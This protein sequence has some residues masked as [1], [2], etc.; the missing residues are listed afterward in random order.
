MNTSLCL[1]FVNLVRAC[2]RARC[3]VSLAGLLALALPAQAQ[4]SFLDFSTGL[5][6]WTTQGGT[7][8]HSSTYSFN[9]GGQPYSLT[10]ATGESMIRITPSGSAV[11]GALFADNSLGLTSGTIGSLLNLG[12]SVTNFGI[13]S[14]SFSLSA[15]TYSFAWAYAA[16]DYQPFNDGVLFSVVGEGTQ[17]VTSLARNGS[18]ASDLSG[19]DPGTLILGSYGSTAWITNTFTVSTNGTYQV[20]FASYNWNDTDLDPVFFVAGTAG[21]FTGTPVGTSGGGGTTPNIDTAAASYNASDLGTSVNPAFEGGTLLANTASVSSDLTID[22]AGGTIQAQNGVGATFSGTISN[23]SGA[24]TGTLTI[25]NSGSGGSVTFTGANTYTGTT[26]VATGATLA[27]SGGGSL[28]STTVNVASGATLDNQNGGLAAGATLTNAGTVNLG[29]DETVAALVNSGTLNGTGRTLTA[30]SYA[31]NNGSIINANLGAGTVTSNGSVALN[32]TS[33]AATVN[34]ASGTLTLGAAERLADTA[35]VSLTG[36]LALGGDETIGSLSG[37]G[38]IALGAHTLTVSSGTYAGV[39]SGTGGLTK[40][41]AGDLTLSGANTFTGATQIGAGTLNLTGS[42][43]ST[44]VNVASGATLD[45]A[46]GG[47]AAGATL[48]NAGSVNLG[49]DDTVAAFVNSGT[50]NGTGHTLTAATYALKNGSIV[51]ANLGTGAVTSN[52][53]VALNGTSAASTVNVASGTLTL[54]AAERLADTAA[55][56]LTGNLALGG[57]ETI[58]SLSGAGG[59]ALGAHTLTVSSGT[60]A[61]VASGTGGLTKT[62]AGDLT[63]SG[64]NTFTGAT[65]IGAGTLNLTGSL[66]STSVNV[67]SG[68]TLDNANGGLAA[69]ATLTNAG[70]VNLGADDTVAAFVNSGTLNGTGRTLSAET[71]AL[72]NGSIVNANLGTG[73]VTSNGSV[74]LNGTSAAATVNVASGTLTLGAAER[75]AD[76]AAVSLS[77]NL[78]LGG[79]E[80]IGS[81]TG[82]GDVALGAHMLT[83][84]S[85]NYAGVASGTGGLTKTGMGDLTLS[86]ANTFTGATQIGAGTLNLTGSLASTS[87]NVASGAVLDNANGGLAAGA[88]LTNAGS[89]NLGAADTVAAF[90]NSGTLNGTGHTLTAATYALNNGSIV[91]AN[92]GTGTVTSNGSV[93]LNGTSAAATVNVASGTLSLGAAERL[94]DTAAV[95]LTGNLALGG[96]ETIGSL[97]G[98]GD[99]ALGA[100]TLTL[101][102]GDYAGIASGTGGLT[103]TGMGDLTLSGANTFTGATQIGAGTL[104]LTGS[105]G[106]ASVNVASGATLENVNGGLAVGATLT[107]AGTVNLGADETVAALVNSGTING[108]GRTLTAATYALNNGSIVNANLG[109]GTVTSNGSVALNGTSA[110]AT[111]NVGSGTLSL[112]A[113]ERLADI[114][115]VSLTGNLALGGNETIGSL[116]GSGDVALGAHTLTVS[117]GNYAGVASGTGGLTKTG[118]GDLTLSGAN[119][120]SGATQ[121][122]AGTLNLTGS[123]ASVSVNVA[124]GAILEN[125]NGGLAANATL[126]NA[127]TVNLG[128]DDVVIAFVSTGTLNGTGRTLSAETYSLDDASVINAN[129]G[130]GTVT[131]NGAVLLNGTSAAATVAVQSGTLTLGAAERLADASVVSVAADAALELTGNETVERLISA[132]RLFGQAGDTLHA[133]LYDL[134]DGAVIDANLGHGTLV[135]NGSVLLNG[136]SAAEEVFVQTGALTLGGPDRLADYSWVDI[137]KDAKLVLANGND[138]VRLLTGEGNVELRN[139][140]VLI[141]HSGVYSGTAYSTGAL[142]KDEA[143]LLTLAGENTYERGTVVRRGE[144]DVAGG[145]RL[146]SEVVV[147]SNGLLRING[148]VQGGVTVESG[149]VL[150]GSGRIEQR[151]VNTGLTSPGNSPGVLRVDGDYIEHSRLLIEIDGRAGAGATGGHDQLSVAGKVVINP[152]STLELNRSVANGFEPGFGDRFLVVNAAGGIEGRYSFLDRRAFGTQLLFDHGTGYVYGT[153]LTA[154]DDFGAAGEGGS[155]VLGGIFAGAV[156]ADDA[157]QLSFFDSRSASGALVSVL[158]SAPSLGEA[159]D[160]LTPVSYVS[161]TDYALHATRNHA[162]N[163]HAGS[164]LA[165]QP[166]WRLTGGYSYLKTGVEKRDGLEYDFVSRGGTVAVE[167]DVT[168]RAALGAFVTFDEG[169][170]D[171]TRLRHEATGLAVGVKGS[172]RSRRPEAWKVEAGASWAGYD[173]EGSR[174]AYLGTHRAKTEATARDAW[175][176]GRVELLRGRHAALAGR[177]LLAYTASEVD[178]FSEEPGLDAFAL[179]RAKDDQLLGEL[180]VEATASPIDRLRVTASAAFVHNFHGT[181]RKV[182]GTLVNGGPAIRV[183]GRGFD[184]DAV[185]LGAGV[186]YELRKGVTVAAGGDALLS[187]GATAARSL[188]VRVNWSF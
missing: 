147:E 48:T 45:N 187:S 11:V 58:G 63:L 52:G 130:T 126:T 110:A 115:A 177:A 83:V 188:N 182:T 28:A 25:A 39:A 17:Q 24:S 75:L 99:V 161:L 6:S 85:G 140:S 153:G 27:L 167:R 71:Y 69:G 16:S 132:G 77:G 128:A 79:D 116:T 30:A 175:A 109:A 125:A 184:E 119:T 169:T 59:I 111:V 97:T 51:N 144:L 159:L 47:L 168:A 118:A 62:G 158:F 26:A 103:K 32:G 40:T 55:V 22:N 100:H 81:L 165:E 86:G 172:V 20:S 137:R 146:T 173:F 15:G 178:A 117:S 13:I 139:G 53:S 102:S 121:I 104:N 120:Y 164:T 19:P 181:R 80:T 42:L 166:G 38:G 180:G 163:A 14:R 34:V 142:L 92:L 123:L 95:S 148:L 1:R 183:S 12:G 155:A 101:S 89:V 141:V 108:T 41:G 18:N 124:S 133:R 127:G 44:S 61:G 8:V 7:F 57:D 33:A 152:G 3:L 136:E 149:G 143:P 150:K 84:S 98:A 174:V 5:A 65:Q 60:Y 56:S 157:G 46:N 88:T 160:A 170:I 4:T 151:V 96:D 67:A 176:G 107:N 68:A 73:A 54:G 23:A 93:A 37:A 106:S 2:R 49:A 29:A 134:R 105:L 78:A 82:S 186:A 9:I 76:T 114:A 156:A 122:G 31:L 64:A 50:L 145:G 91:N 87:V 112:G 74:A 10:P 154:G 179:S 21:S 94:A 135:S 138:I 70:S 43:A 66:A 113:A 162:R 72:N 129:L 171:A 36:N 90:V 35:A 185:R 131:S